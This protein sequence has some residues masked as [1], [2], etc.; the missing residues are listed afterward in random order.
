MEVDYK[1]RSVFP[2]LL[3]LCVYVTL[4]GNDFALKVTKAWRKGHTHVQLPG[5]KKCCGRLLIDLHCR[6]NSLGISHVSQ[7]HRKCMAKIASMIQA[8]AQNS[9]I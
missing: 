4:V 6:I 8:D 7:S 2:G 9:G 3:I 1:H 5:N